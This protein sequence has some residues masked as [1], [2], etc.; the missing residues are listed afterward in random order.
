MP[1][2]SV[3]D[4]RQLAAG[5]HDLGVACG[6]YRFDNWKTLSP[7]DQ[8]KL[9]G[10]EWTLL[11]YSCDFSAEAMEQTLSYLASTLNDI[12]AATDQA[13]KAIKKIKTVDKVIK[14]AAAGAVLGAAIASL[15]PSGVADAVKGV[16]T[17]AA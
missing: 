17:A 13:E 4:I 1:T 3:D 2:L 11:N 8:S 16:Y 6:Q 7:A 14:I 12:K 9:E 5:F 10:L 15:N